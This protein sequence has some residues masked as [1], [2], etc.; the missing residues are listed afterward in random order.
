MLRYPRYKTVV[1]SREP[2]R[3][4]YEKFHAS[5]IEKLT[6]FVYS[7]PIH[8]SPLSPHSRFVGSALAKLKAFR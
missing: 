3:I 2:A 1:T 7:Y 5:L 4:I 6:L 8:R